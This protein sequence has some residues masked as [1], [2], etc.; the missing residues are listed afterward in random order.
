IEVRSVTADEAVRPGLFAR[1]SLTHETADRVVI[2]DRAVVKQT[3]SGDKYVYIVRD[4]KAE[5]VKVELGRR[6][7][8]LYE[9][10]SGVEEG[11]TVVVTGQTRLNDGMEVEII[12]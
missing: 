9:V 8:T 3:G 7:D 4:G 6:M 10:L 1:V 12:K 5:F 2:P 11:D